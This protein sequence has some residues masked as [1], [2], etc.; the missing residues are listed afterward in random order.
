[1]PYRCSYCGGI[2][3]KQHRLPEKHD[4]DGVELLSP[5]GKRFRNKATGR[6]VEK[7]ESIQAPE[8]IEPRYTVGSHPDPEYE[9]SPDVELTPEAKMRR[10]MENRGAGTAD[11]GDT[12]TPLYDRLLNWLKSKLD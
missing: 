12:Y 2:H 9:S 7:G 5:A 10:L 11:K 1:M 6:V 4:C 8:P 3:C